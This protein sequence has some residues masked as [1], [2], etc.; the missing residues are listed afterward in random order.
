M[1]RVQAIPEVQF[2]R[3]AAMQAELDLLPTAQEHRRTIRARLQPLSAQTD[4]NGNLG[5]DLPRASRAR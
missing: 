5:R 1:K 3:I 4:G 2:T